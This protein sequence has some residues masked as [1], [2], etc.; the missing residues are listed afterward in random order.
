[1]MNKIRFSIL[2]ILVYTTQSMSQSNELSNSPYSYYGM[3][4]TNK[5]G[6]GKTNALG[7][8]GIA[9]SS[10]E[11][12][13]NL[14]PASF[15]AIP[16]HSFFYDVGLR[17]Q[18][19][20]LTK[21]GETESKSSGNF[22][23]LALAFPLTEKSGMGI[24]LL[25][26]TNVGYS[27][28]GLETDIE[29]TE[30]QFFSMIEGY[31]GLNDLKVSFG[32]T[33]ND[34]LRIGIAGSLI[35]GKITEDEINIIGTNAIVV[36]K[37]NNHVGG[38][39]GLGVQYDWKENLT[40]GLIINSPSELFG[41]QAQ[42]YSQVYEG[43]NLGGS[44][45]LDLKSFYLPLEIGIGIENNI[46][47]KMTA[48][49]DL[50]RNFWTQ[51]NQSDNVGDYV[52][53]NLL[54]VGLEFSPGGKTLK[55][56]NLI[57]FRGGFEYDTGNLEIGGEKV[58]NFAFNLGLGLPINTKTKSMLNIHYSYGK[59]G[60]L[61]TTLIQENFHLLSVNI[62]LEDLWFVKTKFD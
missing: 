18:Q 45:D 52:D 60:Q 28:Y 15:A 37:I 17:Y 41:G 46:S 9:L 10:T 56:Y 58:E 59:E 3:G 21:A 57:K 50:K 38:R 47:E 32:T 35:F 11:E 61:S 55:Y 31:G 25:P 16:L 29:G 44:F 40:A 2:I 6:P 33:L 4:L 1:M 7:K 22:S 39:I 51:T 8:A 5:L 19:S 30:S 62:S 53:Q 54:G 12:I 48:Y 34:K 49:L 14:N 42:A 26:Y 20:Y 43:Q 27:I 23:S 24:S 36:K 13:N